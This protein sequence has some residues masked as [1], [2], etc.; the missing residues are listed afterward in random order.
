VAFFFSKA[1]RHKGGLLY[2]S[3]ACRILG[4]SVDSVEAEVGI[5]RFSEGVAFER[6]ERTLIVECSCEV[7]EAQGECEHLWAAL[8]VA[9][10]RGLLQGDGSNTSLNLRAANNVPSASSA[11]KREIEKRFEPRLPPAPRPVPE[12]KKRFQK[13]SER[14]QVSDRRTDPWPSNRRLVYA[15]SPQSSEG[16]GA[17]TFSLF[18]QDP[19]KGGGWT[20]LRPTRIR[21]EQ[22]DS[23]PDAADRRIVSLLIG[24][25]PFYDYSFDFGDSIRTTRELAAVILP[26]ITASGRGVVADAA[27]VE[28][29]RPLLLDGGEPWTFKMELTSRGETHQLSGYLARGE[30]QLPLGDS[31]CVV[32]GFFLHRGCLHRYDDRGAVHWLNALRSGGNIVV[33][34]AEFADFVPELLRLPGVPLVDLAAS[35]HMEETAGDPKPQLIVEKKKPWGRERLEAGVWAR[36]GDLMANVRDPCDLVVSRDRKTF[37]RRDSGKERDMLARFEAFGLR[38]REPAEPPGPAVWEIP[39]TR[40]AAVTRD[41]LAEGWAVKAEGQL[42]RRATGW[43]AEVSSGID[44]FG[45]RGEADFD[46]V[47]AGFPELLSA[48]RSGKKMVQLGDGTFG[49]LPEE[50][51]AGLGM[52]A[53]SGALADGEVRFRKNQVG[54]L[55]ALL[56]SRPEVVLDD[57][58]V[59]ARDEL[60]R[61]NGIEPAPQPERFQGELR[62]YQREGLS[63]LHFLR[64]FGFGGCLAD[65]MGVG[66]TPQVLALLESRRELRAAG[67]PIPPSLVVMPKSLVFNWKQECARFTPDLKILDYTG[68][69]RNPGRFTEVD[70]VFTTYGTL[71]RDIST[72]VEQEFDYAI[73]DEAQAVKNPGTDASKAVRLIKASNRL[74]MTGTPVENHL[75]DLWSLFEFLNPG[76]LGSARIFQ[77]AGALR[78]PNEETRAVLSKALRPFIL[79][80]TK[81]QVASELPDKIEQTLFCELDREQRRLYDELRDHYRATLLERVSENGLQRSKIHVLEALLRLRQAACHPALVSTKQKAVASAKFETLLPQLMEVIDDHKVIVFS[82]FTSLLALLE[83]EL[84]RQGIVYEYLDGKT[85]DRETPVQRF[86]NDPRSRVFLISLKAGGVGLNL[87]AAEYVFLLDP[88][89]N[90][91]VELQAIDRA[92]RIGQTRT[93]FAYRLIAKD[94]V[95]E[96]VLT[97]QESKRDLADAI[98]SAD[99]SLIRKMSREDLELLLS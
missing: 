65:D 94:T 2:N 42:F 27:E 99:N 62:G 36:Y 16:A 30:E 7:F 59:K 40:L 85:R 5:G 1:S 73:L 48:I 10:D 57:A 83:Q 26:L 21:K 46:G 51:I 31:E 39:A 32:P 9:D 77:G 95:E 69:L 79:R 87:T 61:F 28:E 72:F 68:M 13:I 43:K 34:S 76:M 74:V 41:L 45:L 49:I 81:Q 64:R 20:K 92:H 91:A 19:K 25:R 89:W 50:W 96:K 6:A 22:V 56:S 54:L 52:L 63:W 80:R 60:M 3:R 17:L 84:E 66:K 88:W 37:A 47:R 67:E 53:G 78:N 82:Q 35:L 23:L 71:R 4:G 93:V 38:L 90:P 15:L 12:W 86:Q 98:I 11:V 44:W 58:F 8:L 75:G 33:R 55:D 24:G 97:L 70:A 18:S 14:T 29:P